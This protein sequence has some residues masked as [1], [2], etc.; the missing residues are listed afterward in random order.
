MD[1]GGEESLLLSYRPLLRGKEALHSKCEAFALKGISSEQPQGI[2]AASLCLSR[3]VHVLFSLN[4]NEGGPQS[5][6][7]MSSASS[8][9]A[10]TALP[11]RLAP[12]RHW[13]QFSVQQRGRSSLIHPENQTKQE[14]GLRRPR[15]YPSGRPGLCFF[16]PNSPGV[17][18]PRCH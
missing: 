16:F 12:F 15:L 1:R 3:Q 8:R 17:L 9:K 10:V 18:S 5:L 13:L 2:G 6:E 4:L 14:E 11:F 7:Q